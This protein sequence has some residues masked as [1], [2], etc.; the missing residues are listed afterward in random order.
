MSKDVN[1]GSDRP[2]KRVL[3]ALIG[4]PY[5]VDR[6]SQ[7]QVATLVE[8]GYRVTVVCPAGPGEAACE[9]INGVRFYRFP[10]PPER[11]GKLDFFREYAHSLCSV[12]RLSWKALRNE[13]WDIIQAANPPDILFIIAGFYKRFFG[14]RFVFDNRDISPEIFAIRFGKSDR[15]LIIRFLLWLERRTYR[16]ADAVMAVN[17][18]VKGLAVGRGGKDPSRVFVVR[19]GIDSKRFKP[20]PPQPDLRMG[21][22]YLVCYAG[23][24]GVQDSVDNLVRTIHHVVHERGRTDISFVLLGDGDELERLTALAG[25]LGVDEY[26]SFPGFVRDDDLLLAYMSTADVCVSP[27]SKNPFN[28]MCSFVKINEYLAMG[29]PVVLFDLVEARKS[30]GDAAVYVTPNDTSEFGDKIID[31]LDDP[32]ECARMGKIALERSAGLLSW[33][34]SQAHFLAAYDRLFSNT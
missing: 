31:L 30:A 22:R 4:K 17:E 6:R 16:T 27:E 19:C 25:D 23:V 15:S 32:A 12:M 28:D 18:S 33:E 1:S 5:S 20:V 2:A 24:M 3:I 7:L 14:K 11:R 21:R 9:E 29:K 13:G 34:H 26:T 8:H 10:F